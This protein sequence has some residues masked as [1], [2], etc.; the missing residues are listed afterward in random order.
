MQ[1]DFE[2]PINRSKMASAKWEKM[3]ECN[4]SVSEDIFPFSVADADLPL[5]PE[6][7]EGL[8]DYIDQTVLGYTIV[9][10]DYLRAVKEWNKTK[11]HFELDTD[12]ILTTPGV[13]PALHLAVR[14]YTE[15]GDSVVIMT[16]IYPPFYNAVTSQDRHLSEVPLLKE[17]THYSIDFEQ[18]E[19]TV[20]DPKVT[21]LLF[22]S[23]HNP[24]GRVWTK[25]ELTRV[26]EIC[27]ANGVKIVSD[28]IHYDL[29][30]PG[31][32]HTVFA[33]INDTVA[34]HVVVCTSA[35]KTFNI[36][37]LQ[38][39]A[40]IIPNEYMRERFFTEMDR[41]GYHGANMIGLKAT[42][43]AYTKGSDWLDGFKDLIAH[44][45]EVLQQFVTKNL[46]KATAFPL[47]GTYLQW[48]DLR[49]YTDLEALED[50]L[51]HK[52]NLFFNEGYH[53]GESGKG[54]ERINLACPT[55]LLVKALDRLAEVFNR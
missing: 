24:V 51:T 42:E 4:P 6:I 26:A 7:K 53:F 25:E 5:A 15:P 41:I 40:V 20:S 12:W 44:N 17:G 27:I 13:V 3:K 55:A 19:R 48:I 37:G 29:V 23:P 45:A 18:L 54:Y 16:P 31:H 39:A 9:S 33:A 49:P 52:G 11:H 38:T 2:T 47:E 21:L 50:T 46:P 10:P 28:E 32:E 43:L 34:E 8:K 35:S 1:Y 36:A 22:C 30:M 14:A